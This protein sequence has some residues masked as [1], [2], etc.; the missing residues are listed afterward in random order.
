MS[1]LKNYIYNTIYQIMLLIVPLITMPYLTR[2]FSPNQTGLNAY[3]S[4]IV[5]YFMLFGLLGIQMY[6]N[7]QIAY[8]RDSKEKLTET[9]WSLYLIQLTTTI[10][11]VV[12][13]L[14]FSF[15]F[16]KEYR[17]IYLVQGLA[18][19]SSVMDI[20]WFF[21]GLEDFKK[22]SIRNMIVKLSGL[23]GIF[24][25][26]RT[27]EDL[28]LYIFINNLVSILGMLVMWRYVPKYVYNIKIDIK[29]MKKTLIPLLVLFL[30]QI[31]SQVY[32]VLSRTLIG[33]FSTTDQV[34]FY[35]YSQK[36]VR[37]VLAL[38][39]SVGTVLMPRVSNLNSNGKKEE[40][41]NFV[42]KAFI[43]ISYISVPMAFG[44]MGV[45]E[46]L[47]SWFLGKE[48]FEVGKLAS[49]SSII[50]IA[51][52][53]ANI[54][55]I[56]YLV[57][58]RQ[59]NK[60]TLSVIISSVLSILTNIIVIPKLGAL[61][62]VISLIVAEFSGSIIQ[63]ILVRK[64]LKITNMLLSTVKYIIAGLI[65]IMIIMPIGNIIENKVLANLIQVI[66]GMIIYIGIIAMTK[67]RV[68]N[69]ML[70]MVL[71]IIN[72]RILRK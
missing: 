26:V 14:L 72:R 66:I 59:E 1:I 48:Y 30:P 57:A 16:I 34:S 71:S 24:L 62:A 52:S 54:I 31:S 11:S 65:M 7:R 43:F 39:T 32:T 49:I 20:S 51:V 28:V 44:L 9:F 70:K 58:T 17:N 38:I 47:I 41:N 23:I 55:G 6:G 22:V 35:D 40:I 63:L 12:A 5:T 10:L 4:S 36:I 27:S 33:I 25:F 60:Y 8:V 69:E 21:M 46:N 15:I 45:S 3:T 29:L 13:Y 18:L 56:Q 64:Q 61:G 2:I 53:W 37:I 42:S 50:I 67:D 19:I 68:Q